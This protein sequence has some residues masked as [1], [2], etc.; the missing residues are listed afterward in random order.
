MPRRSAP[1]RLGLRPWFG[2]CPKLKAKGRTKGLAQTRGE[3]PTAR[4]SLASH[5]AAKP[6]LL[7]PNFKLGVICKDGLTSR[8]RS[9]SDEF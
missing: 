1:L 9:R 6:E 7:E 4:L 2:L 5:Q 8:R 3:I